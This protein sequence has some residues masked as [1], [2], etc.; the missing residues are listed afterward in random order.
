MS[1]PDGEQ[2]QQ[3]QQQQ[4]QLP[5]FPQDDDDDGG[6]SQAAA[7][8]SE[9]D[10]SPDVDPVTRDLFAAI[11]PE[12]VLAERARNQGPIGAGAL[13]AAHV[14]PALDAEFAAVSI[15]TV[16]DVYAP[17]ASYFCAFVSATVPS[18]PDRQEEP[19]SRYGHLLEQFVQT[20]ERAYAF[21]RPVMLVSV[22]AHTTEQWGA[23]Y[24]Q[25]LHLSSV[26]VEYGHAHALFRGTLHL[27]TLLYNLDLVLPCAVCTGHYLLIKETA[28]VLDCVREVAF[29]DCVIGVH[30][31]HSLVTH[32]I[33]V[34]QRGAPPGSVAPFRIADFAFRYGFIS[35]HDEHRLVTDRYI[36]PRV[37]WQPPT[38]VALSVLLAAY[39]A[40]PYQRASNALKTRLYP[41]APETVPTLRT[42]QVPHPWSAVREFQATDRLFAQLGP[43]QL[44]HCLGRM[45]ML[46]LDGHATGM[47]PAHALS[48]PTL[49]R[50]FAHLARHFPDLL[51]AVADAHIPNAERR[52]QV[53]R[54]VDS[55]VATT[56]AAAAA[57]AA[58]S[59]SAEEAATSAPQPPP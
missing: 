22:A 11:P 9:P 19:A 34:T 55:V 6:L 42:Q 24:W 28:P 27:A 21:T 37:D 57:A 43:H 47:Q 13:L 33:A 15:R 31:F 7:D 17:A 20:L 39:C 4:L 1:G 48:Q 25:F 54:Y 18:D 46:K 50:S 14:W 58:A 40:Q 51:R 29:G 26:L 49:M 5:P 10:P 23:V 36:Q 38:H 3:Q 52:A 35:L 32:N 30:R 8:F 12:E 59:A 41:T 45:L 16:V 53:H 56:A 2:Q 44:A